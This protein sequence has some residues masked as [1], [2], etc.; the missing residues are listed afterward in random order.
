[1]AC[2]PTPAP[3][4]EGVSVVI[5]SPGSGSKVAVGQEVSIDA[6]AAADAGVDRVELSVNGTLVSRDMPPSG[7]PTTFRVVQSWTPEVEGPATLSVVAFD[8]DGAASDAATIMLQVGDGEGDGPGTVMPPGLT[9]TSLPPVTTD[10]GC[11]P[12]SQYV[13]DVT[14][15]DG[16]VMGQG[17]AFVKTWR[18]RNS[19][20][21]DWGA[22]YELVF[23][24]GAQMGGPT[25]VTLPAIAAGGEA[26]VSVDLTAPSTYGTHK[27]TWRMRADDGTPFG[28]NLSVVVVVP[29]P[30]TDTPEPPPVTDTPEPTATDTPEPTEET[31]GPDLIVSHLVVA[32]ASVSVGQKVVVHVRVR[33]VGDEPAGEFL[34]EWKAPGDEC[35]WGVAYLDP[36][37]EVALSICEAGITGV[38]SLPTIATVDST[39]DVDE[40]NEDNNARVFPVTVLKP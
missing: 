18:V 28:V 12:D 22:G 27:G 30:V 29:A 33:N 31:L 20:T 40:V 21:C 10:A 25:S 38:G 24:S 19:G 17:Q 15:P 37:Q 4:G 8:V 5:N 14:V 34:V 32:P 11:T 1:M 7:N 16:T 2:G 13:A 35:A 39:G 9:E 6:T 23:V 36:G 3:E 26:D